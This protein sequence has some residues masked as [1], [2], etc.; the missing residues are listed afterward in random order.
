MVEVIVS[1]DLSI[2]RPSQGRS[3]LRLAYNKAFSITVASYLPTLS[4]RKVSSWE[5]WNPMKPAAPVTRTV[6][7]SSVPCLASLTSRTCFLTSGLCLFTASV[8]SCT[9]F[10]SCVCDNQAGSD[11]I[12]TKLLASSAKLRASRSTL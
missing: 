2:G 3:D 9:L 7:L 5:R 11:R 6:F 1:D 4:P 12:C 10:V 8:R